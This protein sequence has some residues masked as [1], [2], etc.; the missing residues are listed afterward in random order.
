LYARAGTWE[1]I[2]EHA[3][4]KQF[5]AATDLFFQPMQSSSGIWTGIVDAAVPDPA[6]VARAAPSQRPRRWRSR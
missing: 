2:A 3:N 5:G 1:K 4:A 6:R